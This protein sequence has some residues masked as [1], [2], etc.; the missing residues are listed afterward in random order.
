MSKKEGFFKRHGSKIKTWTNRIMSVC[1]FGLVTASVVGASIPAGVVVIPP[2]LAMIIT[3][4]VKH[5]PKSIAEIKDHLSIKLKDDPEGL[6]EVIDCLSDMHSK[7]EG[8]ARSEPISVAGYVDKTKKKEDETMSLYSVD[9]KGLT[10]TF[11]NEP[12][13][14]ELTPVS[15]KNGGNTTQRRE[16][17]VV[18]NEKTRKLEYVVEE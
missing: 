10:K 18:F 6:T 16:V 12:A 4:L 3:L 17:K 14:E 5:G 9:D 11:H 13:V 15:P 1:S 8:S 7:F 2:A